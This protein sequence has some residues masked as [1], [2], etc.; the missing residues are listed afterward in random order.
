MAK[1][2]HRD[3][4][5][6][7]SCEFVVMINSLLF[8]LRLVAHLNIITKMAYNLKNNRP[9]LHR[10]SKRSIF[11]TVSLKIYDML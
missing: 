2:K 3:K 7:K 1:T 6:Q 8:S 4:T 11:A 10:E 9:S 5:R